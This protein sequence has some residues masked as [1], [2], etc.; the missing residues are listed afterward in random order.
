MHV[1]TLEEVH[2]QAKRLP[3]IQK[4]KI[5]KPSLLPG[6]EFVVP[7]GLR[8][9]LLSDGRENDLPGG[10]PLLPAE[11]ALFLT[12]YRLIFKGNPI[13]PFASEHVVTRFF[14]VT[15][16][17]RE[18]RFSVNEYLSGIEQQLPCS[19][20]DKTSGAGQKNGWFGVGH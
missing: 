6:E 10:V 5:N 20:S 1:E 4:P 14:P 16:L 18:K 15:S 2:R 3:P 17:T 7:N 13:D 8:V 9:Y 11:G 19:R 12:T